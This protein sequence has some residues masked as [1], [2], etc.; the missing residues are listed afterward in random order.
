MKTVVNLINKVLYIVISLL[1]NKIFSAM[2][3]F[4]KLVVAMQRIIVNTIPPCL[5]G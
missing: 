4:D 3:S 2:V 1:L 5:A